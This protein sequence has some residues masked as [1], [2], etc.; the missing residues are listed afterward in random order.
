MDIRMP[1]LDG[2]AGD[3]PAARA[4]TATARR[5]SSILTT[6][7]RNEYV[8]EALRAGASGFLLKDMPGEQLVDGLRSVAR[9]RGA[10]RAVGHPPDDRGVRRA[11]STRRSRAASTELTERER[12]TF[13]AV[14]RGLS[15]AEIAA[16]HVVTEATV[17]THVAQ[18][19]RQARPARPRAGGRARLRDRP[20]EAR[21]LSTAREAFGTRGRVDLRPSQRGARAASCRPPPSAPMQRARAQRASSATSARAPHRMSA[22]ERGLLA[23]E[24]AG[25]VDRR[26]VLVHGVG[27]DV[28][29][30]EVDRRRSP[31][32]E[33][34]Q[35]ARVAAVGQRRGHLEQRE[36][37]RRS[38]RASAGAGRTATSG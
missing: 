2:L 36:V 22:R 4:A 9:G 25:E 29:V 6:F 33:P 13:L 20:G 15:N 7:D 10:A 32:P 37:A 3:A 16:E 5:A 34:A 12:A 35:A 21:R 18:R 27:L 28:L 38:R 14:A 26:D 19:A 30:E 17:K 1:R 8:Y 11:S 24:A 31:K 23:R